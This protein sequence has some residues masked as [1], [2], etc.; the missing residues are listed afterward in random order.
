MEAAQQCKKT[1][2]FDSEII[3]KFLVDKEKI[4]YVNNGVLQVSC[5]KNTTSEVNIVSDQAIQILNFQPLV[6]DLDIKIEELKLNIKSF[7]SS[8]NEMLKKSSKNLRL[9]LKIGFLTTKTLESG[10]KEL[11]FKISPAFLNKQNF[12]SLIKDP[13]PKIY[14]SYCSWQNN[15]QLNSD[16]ERDSLSIISHKI[17]NPVGM[18]PVKIVSITPTPPVPQ[19]YNFKP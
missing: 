14:D 2:I 8:L 3:G 15:T 18:K 5:G 7:V 9:D 13:E 11:E 17:V 19:D 10:E 12:Q 16:Q 6:D 4:T 1:I